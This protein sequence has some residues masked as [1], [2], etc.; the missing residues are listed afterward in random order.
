MFL[1]VFPKKPDSR[2][3][4]T[5]LE[6]VIRCAGSRTKYLVCDK[7][8]VFWCKT[9]KDWCRSKA[10]DPRYGAVGE[11]GSIA[12][13]ER[14]IRALKNGCTRR[15][16][17]PQRQ[18][19]FSSEL[20]SF[21]DWYN[22][23]RHHMTLEGSTPNEVSFGRCPANRFLGSNLAKTGLGG[24][25]VAKPCTLVAGQPGD[26]FSLEVG[27]YGP[28]QQPKIGDQRSLDHYTTWGEL[29]M[30]TRTRCLT[31]SRTSRITPSLMR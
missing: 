31:R 25:G 2:T 8:K 28:S 22:E 15:L 11:H 9:F 14:A 5:F 12:V 18:R 21:Q 13:V 23:H 4:C 20:L 1:A 26:R 19:E 30:R 29:P 3:V 16:L 10:V 7:D 6:S 27:Y 24:R 17:V